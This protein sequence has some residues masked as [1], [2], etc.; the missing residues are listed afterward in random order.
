M[1]LVTFQTDSSQTWGILRDDGIVDGRKLLNGRF[2]SVREIIAAD[3]CKAVEAAAAD[4]AS[5]HTRESV[6]LLPPIPDPAKILCVGLNYRA[7]A[8]EAGRTVPPYPSSFVRLPNTLIGD[9]A[10]IPLPR[11]SDALDFEGELAVIIG[12]PGRH[13]AEADALRHIAGYSC[14]NDASV[15]DYQKHA[16]SA[17][18]NFFG[19]APFGPCLVTADEIPD[20]QALHLTTRLNGQRM[21]SAST[22]SMMYSIAALIH[23]FSTITPLEPGDVIATGTPA[24]V[25]L[26]RTPH[27]WMRHGDVIEVEIPGIGLLRNHVCRE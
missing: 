13:I 17:G 10:G 1:R 2:L 22:S 16:V 6:R 25:G 11:V 12:R 18:K 23:Y 19:T 15:R 7:H 3:A 24:G 21:Q 26:G 20:P 14:F 5:D 8:E 27:V 4:M 9:G